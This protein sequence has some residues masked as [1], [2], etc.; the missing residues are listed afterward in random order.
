MRSPFMDPRQ[1]IALR[2]TYNFFKAFWLGLEAKAS[3]RSAFMED[4]YFESTIAALEANHHEFTA[5]NLAGHNLRDGMR[6]TNE[7]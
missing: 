1:L 2:P 7:S 6:D 3:T 4:K 5:V